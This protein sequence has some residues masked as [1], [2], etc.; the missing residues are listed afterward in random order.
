M[1]QAGDKPEGRKGGKRRQVAALPWRGEG[2]DL[3]VLLVSSRET[4]RWVI[5]KGWPMTG[6]SPPDAAAQEAAEEAGIAGEA[7]SSPIGSY[8]YLKKLKDGQT[9]PAQVIVF[10]FRVSGRSDRWKEEGQRDHRWFRAS[11]AATLVAEPA[12]RRLIREFGRARAPPLF[13]P[14]PALARWIDRGLLLLRG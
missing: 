12:L 13:R 4:R 5:P 7:E 2:E 8:H 14:P 3:R 9:V 11:R 6:L 10:P 1:S